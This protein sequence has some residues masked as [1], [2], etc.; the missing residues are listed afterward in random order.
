MVAF[1]L[2][3]RL[4][5]DDRGR[6]VVERLM[7]PLMIVAPKVPVESAARDRDRHLVV[8]VYRFVLDGAP[9]AFDEHIVQSPPATI[10]ADVPIRRPQQPRERVAR[11]LGALIRVEDRRP[12]R[13]QGPLQRVATELAVHRHR[14]FPS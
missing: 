12:E 2:S 6:S 5:M 11:K 13:C 3:R 7:G 10:H 8:Q 4:R 1:R 9:L 14:Q